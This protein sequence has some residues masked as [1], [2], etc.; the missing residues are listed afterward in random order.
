MESGIK[1]QMPIPG[2]MHKKLGVFVGKWHT[3][4]HIEPI[5]SELRTTVDAIDTYEWY[6]GAFFLV[7]D[8][9]AKMG[10]ESVRSL[11]IIG[12]DA[13]RK[14]YLAT[15]YDNT[16]GY[17]QEAIY[18]DDNIWMWRGSNVMGVKEHR[19]IAVV[20]ED[21][22]TIHARHEQSEDSENWR[23]WMDV[24]LKKIE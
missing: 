8:A 7:H 5:G 11:E 22:K 1:T 19:C 12:Y 6:P 16:G 23:L 2:A 17:G 4:G 24:T 15:F 3:T 20:S 14:C 18:L 10:E 13:N 9:D 21:G